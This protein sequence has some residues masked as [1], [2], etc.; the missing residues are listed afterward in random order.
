M[1][2]AGDTSKAEDSPLAGDANENALRKDVRWGQR[3]CMKA[4]LNCPHIGRKLAREITPALQRIL[5]IPHLHQLE[6]G[7]Y[8]VHGQQPRGKHTEDGKYPGSRD[9][10]QG[11][12]RA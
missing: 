5:K 6:K 9:A 4:T 11:E 12:A 1:H 2:A 8:S 3:D 10:S 7:A